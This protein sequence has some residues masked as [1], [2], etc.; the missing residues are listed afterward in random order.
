M[1]AALAHHVPGRWLGH[2]RAVEHVP[3]PGRA[4]QA[5]TVLD[6]VTGGRFIL[7]LGAGWHDGEHDAVRDPAPADAASGFDR[8]ESAVRVLRA[9]C[10]AEAATPPGVTPRRSLVSARG[11]R[12]TLPPP[13]RP[14]G[15][16]IWLGGQKRRG[17]APGGRAGRRL[18]PAVGL[19][20]EGADEFS[21]FGDRRT[22]PARDGRARPRRQLVRLRWPAAGRQDRRR[23]RA[24][25]RDRPAVHR[26]GATHVILGMAARLGPDRPRRGRSRGR[27]TPPCRARLTV[28]RGGRFRNRAS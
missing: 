22:T 10:S 11:T 18:G 1:A 27:R 2:R 8:F 9:L 25:A 19:P 14:G 12:R 26:G 17:I 20:D 24:G 15:P 23:A 4:G 21:Y 28:D 16:P 13:A 6:H 3:P 7:G 5:A